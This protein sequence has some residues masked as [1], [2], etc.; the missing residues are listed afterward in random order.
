MKLYTFVSFSF[1]AEA[2][3]LLEQ[4][5]REKELLHIFL[6]ASQKD[7]QHLR[8]LHLK[9]FLMVPVQRIMK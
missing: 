3:L 8:K 1:Q 6:Q 7:N 2:P 5:E 9:A 4:F